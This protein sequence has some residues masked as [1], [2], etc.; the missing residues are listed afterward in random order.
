MNKYELILILLEGIASVASAL[1]QNVDLLF[2]REMREYLIVNVPLR[3]PG[4]GQ[5]PDFLAF[6]VC[7]VGIVLMLIGVKESSHLNRI[8]AVFYVTLLS[9]IILIGATRANF[10]NWNLTP[11][12]TFVFQ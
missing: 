3:T 11:N 8:F 5:Y 1:S 4:L 2:N 12:V 7:C 9:L 10:S 6:L